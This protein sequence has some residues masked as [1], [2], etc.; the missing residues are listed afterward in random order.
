MAIKNIPDSCTI[1][2]YVK[3]FAIKKTYHAWPAV[4]TFLITVFLESHASYYRNSPHFIGQ[5]MW[6]SE[7]L[8][9]YKK[10]FNYC[11]TKGVIKFKK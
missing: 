8:H 5:C 2:R 4:D 11:I 10:Y 6:F 7:A 1:S 3:S 9:D